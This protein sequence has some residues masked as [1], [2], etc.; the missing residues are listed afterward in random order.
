[1]EDVA[2][3]AQPLE[4]PAST[5][6]AG[7]VSGAEASGP[8]PGPKVQEEAPAGVEED[9]K[10][11]QEHQQQEPSQH[12]GDV[13]SSA[14]DQ[15]GAELDLLAG[16]TIHEQPNSPAAVPPAGTPQQH[17]PSTEQTQ[18]ATPQPQQQQDKA[19]ARRDAAIAQA[20]L[21]THAS[22]L[23]VYGLSALHDAL[24]ERQLAVFFRN[25]HFNVIFK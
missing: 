5:L 4:T 17:Q 16:L 8:G 1:V 18:Q 22:Q 25:N 2:P 19:S 11:E 15:L 7:L 21:E 13:A 23:T 14:A 6:D 12:D 10:Q 9:K 3:V 20:F 24:R